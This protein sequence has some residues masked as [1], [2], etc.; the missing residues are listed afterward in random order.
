[1]KAFH[2]RF[3]PGQHFNKN[4]S[5]SSVAGRDEKKSPGLPGFLVFFSE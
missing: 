1:M 5:V 2:N 4:M 3:L